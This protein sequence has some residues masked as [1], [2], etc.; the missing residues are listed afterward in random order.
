MKRDLPIY[1][2]EG[3]IFCV[4][5]MHLRLFELHNPK[6]VLHILDMA[7]TRKMEKGETRLGYEF[8]YNRSYKNIVLGP[9]KV[10]AIV[11]LPEL[12]HLDP[13]G[14]AVRYGFTMDQIVGLTDFEVM[15][16][17]YA[18]SMRL[19]GTLPTINLPGNAVI[20]VDAENDLL[21]QQNKDV[22]P[23][24]TFDSIQ[25]YF[26]QKIMAYV[27]PYNPETNQLELLSWKSYNAMPQE[28][29]VAKIPHA[30]ILDRVGYNRRHGAP[31]KAGLKESN[32]TLQHN[33]E[34]ISWNKKLLE[35]VLKN[36]SMLKKTKFRVR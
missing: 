5:V 7:E 15:V 17:Q 16:D 20:K 30:S 1:E 2:I 25:P 36:S 8:P 27:V 14:M 10:D 23:G 24:I 34:I 11:T 26:L 9:D 28:I 13:F 29:Y 19:Q 6:N 22:S 18:F 12:V 4:D 32:I 33:V 35:K 31:E 21:I 3:T